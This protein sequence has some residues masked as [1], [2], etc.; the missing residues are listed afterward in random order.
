MAATITTWEQ[1]PLFDPTN[2][3]QIVEIRP[4]WN[5]GGSAY[6]SYFYN[7]KPTTA[8]LQGVLDNAPSWLTAGIVGLL[9]LGAGFLGAKYV[10]PRIKRL[11]HRGR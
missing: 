6:G 5:P 8:K 4:A 10:G 11:F 1:S 9:G 3:N 2:P 7:Q